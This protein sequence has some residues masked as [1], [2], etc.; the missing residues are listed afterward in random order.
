MEISYQLTEDDYRQGFKAFRRRTRYSL[1]ANRFAYAC[2]TLV[3]GGALLL[4]SF[5]NE[6]L[7]RLVPLWALVVFWA[8]FIW[9]CPYHLA[10]KM[11]KGSPGAVAPHTVDLSE[12][13]FHSRTSIS[14]SQIN[15]EL[16]VGWGEVER[17]FA[18][19]PSPLSFFPIPKRSMTAE[20]QNE[21]RSL[22]QDKI[23]RK[24]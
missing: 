10:K 19:F 7:P 21:L 4:T 9:Y 5:G 20:Q 16:F 17:V 2:F 23:P 3:L 24:R 18:L 11:I 12:A 6:S 8:W 15:W 1:W 14:E 22:L 13:G